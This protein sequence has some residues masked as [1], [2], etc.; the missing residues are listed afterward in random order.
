[1]LKLNNAFPSPLILITLIMFLCALASEVQCQVA[2]ILN[3][4]LKITAPSFTSTPIKGWPVNVTAD[5]LVMRDTHGLLI[6]IPVEA[7]VRCE[8]AAGKSSHVGTGILI[9]AITG[10]VAGTVIAANSSDNFRSKGSKFYKIT[11]ATGLG[12]LLGAMIGSSIESDRWIEI[13][14]SSLRITL[15]NALDSTFGL[16]LALPF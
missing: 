4:K 15:M 16:A 14:N 13:S 2:D 12:V 6:R 7:V 5:T 8:M 9:G 3:K 11:G 10:A 1:M